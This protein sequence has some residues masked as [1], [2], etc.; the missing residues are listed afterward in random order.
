MATAVATHSTKALKGG[1]SKLAQTLE[2]L[3]Q[4]PKFQLSGVANL[5]VRWSAKN[6][7][8]GARWAVIV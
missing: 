1:P 3:N 6:N 8:F 5:K 7:S 2:R 4:Q